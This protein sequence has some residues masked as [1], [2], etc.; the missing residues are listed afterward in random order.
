MAKDDAQPDVLRSTEATPIAKLS[1]AVADAASLVVEGV[2]TVTWP[3]S[4]VSKSIA[5]ILA[6]RDP[7]HRRDKG[8]LRVEFHGA[9]GKALADSS[10]GGGDEVRLSLDGVQWEENQAWMR[11]PGILEWQMK[12]TNRLLLKIRRADTQEVDTI[13]VDA[14]DNEGGQESQERL[15]EMSPSPSIETEQTHF[16]QPLPRTPLSTIPSKRFAYETLGPGEYASPAFLKRARVSYGSLFEGGFD[17]FDEDGPSKGAEKKKAKSR[18]SMNPTSWRYTSRSPTPEVEQPAGD[19]DED[20]P[21][22]DDTE[23]FVAE[24]QTAKEAETGHQLPATQLQPIMVDHACQTRELSSSPVRGV[25][26]IAESKSTGTLL[27]PTPTHPWKHVDMNHVLQEPSPLSFGY[28]AAHDAQSQVHEPAPIRQS[29]MRAPHSIFDM[30]M[31]IDP[32]LQSHEANAHHQHHQHHQ[33]TY[34]IMAT[35]MQPPQL[36]EHGFHDTRPHDGLAWIAEALAPAYPTIPTHNVQHFPQGSFDRSSYTL[37]ASPSDETHTLVS[38]GH[39][40]TEMHNYVQVDEARNILSSSYAQ[41]DGVKRHNSYPEHY[42][43]DTETATVTATLG[44]EGRSSPPREDSSTDES[45]DE[46]VEGVQHRYYDW[47][48]GQWRQDNPEQV[49]DDQHYDERGSDEDDMEEGS[50]EDDIDE[51]EYATESEPESESKSESRV[52]NEFARPAQPAP[53]SFLPIP[54]PAP[55]APKE[56]IFISLLSDSEDDGDDEPTPTKAIKELSE[57]PVHHEDDEADEQP[58]EQDDEIMDEDLN[59]NMD[60]AQDESVSEEAAEIRTVVT[61]SSK[62]SSI[63]SQLDG[64]EEYTLHQHE[65][66]NRGDIIRVEMDHPN[67]ILSPKSTRTYRPYVDIAENMVEAQNEPQ[68][69]SSPLGDKISGRLEFGAI[70]TMNIEEITNADMCGTSKSRSSE[71]T[72][73]A[74][75][76]VLEQ[77]DEAPVAEQEQQQE[78]Q[79]EQ[80]TDSPRVGLVDSVE[81]A[82]EASLQTPDIP[83]EMTDVV[84]APSFQPTTN[85]DLLMEDLQPTTSE[86]QPLNVEAEAE[87]VDV[88]EPDVEMQDDV[89]NQLREETESVPKERGNQLDQATTDVVLKTTREPEVAAPTSPPATQAESSQPVPMAVSV[90]EEQESTKQLPTP[91]QTQQDDLGDNH[92][93]IGEVQTEMPLYE[94][95]MNEVADGDVDGDEDGDVDED[96]YEDAREEGGDDDDFAIEQQLMS[97]F[98]H[99]SSPQKTRDADHREP[100]FSQLPET[101]QEIQESQQSQQDQQSQRSQQSQQREQS[102]HERSPRR[103]EHEMLITLQS[104]RSHCRAKRL[105]SDSADSLSTDPSI[106]L[107]RGSPTMA[108]HQCLLGDADSLPQRSPRSPRSRA[109]HSDPSVALAKSSPRESG[110]PKE[111]GASASLRTRRGVKGASDASIL[112]AQA[113]SLPSG[114]SP[115]QP[116]SPTASFRAGRRKSDKSDLSVQLA[117]ASFNKGSQQEQ[118]EEGGRDAAQD[119]SA[120][121]RG[122]GTPEPTL[123]G[124]NLRS[125]RK[126][127]VKPPLK[128][129]SVA[130]SV[131]EDGNVASLKLQLL[132]GLRTNLPDCLPLKSLRSCLTRMADILAVATIT[133]RQPH[134]PK[135]GPRDYMLELNLTDPSVAPTG[136]NVAHIFRPHQASL[137]TVQAGDIVLLRR[138]Q[139]VSMQGRGFGIRAGDA[140]AWAIFERDDEEMLPQI[141]GP[142]VEVADEEIEYVQGLRRWWGLQDDKTLAKID[143]ANQRMSQAVRDET[144]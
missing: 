105:S 27:Q 97:E 63:I 119:A 75:P 74:I 104:L 131:A 47:S 123:T 137:P 85:D 103:G 2:V 1:P 65:E 61:P 107:A 24:E 11:R 130:S 122:E 42:E 120:N 90:I 125:P 18:F 118:E 135:H 34:D 82:A 50:D 94:E 5:F 19:E 12:F 73:I 98:Q 144:K 83:M 71:P 13:N 26:I 109:E 49:Y 106:L 113:F 110:S 62:R 56:P 51:E 115:Q 36:Q 92:N 41:R 89:L 52:Y 23:T 46:E 78:E 54:K 69:P 111:T 93:V 112:L 6:E 91:L 15:R 53:S 96:E 44:R 67:L 129:A 101:I 28:V 79:E 100:A 102:M 45:E 142:P 32:S 116:A 55:A 30:P 72:N 31:N 108:H 117:T 141:K 60:E 136:V 77:N 133:P 81:P 70:N 84:E 76:A 68:T 57:E 40:G 9:A 59:E 21:K 95:E 127:A 143:K 3:Y 134:R 10:L 35:D 124:H 48:T 22:L 132:R 128:P 17:I 99:Y 39:H 4:V 38:S 114:R 37:R 88:A 58:L 121:P 16:A 7:L 139:V 8:Q 64:C 14:S 140:S 80:H 138:V 29:E 87:E 25:Q 43:E 86:I 20:E 66:P 33:H 126:S